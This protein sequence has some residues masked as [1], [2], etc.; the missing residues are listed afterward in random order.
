MKNGRCLK[1]AS[2]EVYRHRNG[3]ELSFKSG[4]AY[5]DMPCDT[6]VCVSCGFLEQ[7]VDLREEDPNL[8]AN[9]KKSW[10]KVGKP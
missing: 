8:V 7:F 2:T 3:T 4:V 6:Y 10:Q 5:R 9:I 1:C